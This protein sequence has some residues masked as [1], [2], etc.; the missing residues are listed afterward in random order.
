[1]NSAKYVK[2]WDF[3]ASQ[4]LDH[5]LAELTKGKWARFLDET[6]LIE[7]EETAE[8]ISARLNPYLN[9]KGD[10]LLVVKFPDNITDY[11][12]CM[13]AEQWEWITKCREEEKGEKENNINAKT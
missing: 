12:G 7:S 3:S 4:R 6:W 1:M 2:W 13:P 9:G 11:F 8:Q 5:F 10:F